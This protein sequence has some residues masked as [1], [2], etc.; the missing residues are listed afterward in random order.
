MLILSLGACCRHS[1][2]LSKRSTNKEIPVD[3]NCVYILS[4]KESTKPAMLAVLLTIGHYA[5]FYFFTCLL[6]VLNTSKKSTPF[7]LY[8]KML[9]DSEVSFF[10]SILFLLPLKSVS[11]IRIV[12]KGE[13]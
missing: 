6:C 13:N 10:P 4:T 1:L 2:V 12:S 3:V 8:S 5:T 7:L 11:D 9:L